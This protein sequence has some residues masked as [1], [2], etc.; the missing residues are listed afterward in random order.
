MRVAQRAYCTG[1]LFAVAV[2]PLPR[3]V[4]YAV[5]DGGPRFEAYE[6]RECTE[7][8]FEEF[9]HFYIS[10]L[11]RGPPGPPIFYESRASSCLKM[12]PMKV[13]A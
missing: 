4:D 11:V 8:G 12:T 6:K 5:I 9:F 10:F 13:S 2:T 1:T 7:H 3:V